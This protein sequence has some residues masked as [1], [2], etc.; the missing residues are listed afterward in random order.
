MVVR[1]SFPHRSSSGCEDSY[2][3]CRVQT[4]SPVSN[5]PVET[6]PE[7][8]SVD[9]PTTQKQDIDQ[10]QCTCVSKNQCSNSNSNEYLK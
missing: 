5:S 10:Q 8:S 9:Y 6:S 2:V 4:E 7:V 3:C 1:S